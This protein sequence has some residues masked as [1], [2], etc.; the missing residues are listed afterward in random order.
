MTRK[1]L[2]TEEFTEA[3]SYV[4][5]RIENRL[6]IDYELIIDMFPVLFH[7]EAREL[8]IRRKYLK[9]QGKEVYE[10]PMPDD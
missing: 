4:K 6:P 2:W 8:A 9:L 3:H 1:H 7:D 10:L 5:Y